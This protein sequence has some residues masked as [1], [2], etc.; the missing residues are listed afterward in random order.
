M[1]LIDEIRKK[2]I[3]MS[4]SSPNTRLTKALFVASGSKKSEKYLATVK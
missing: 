4:L 3:L 1:E 2:S